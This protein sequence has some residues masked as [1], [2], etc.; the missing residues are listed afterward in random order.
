MRTSIWAMSLLFATLMG[1]F[2]LSAAPVESGAA[3]LRGVTEPVSLSGLWQLLFGLIAVLL[4][5]AVGAWLMRR[6]GSFSGTV[7]G[8]IK[9]ISALSLG[10]RERIM[11][12]QV[13][14][15]QVLIG[16]APGQIRTLH[17]LKEPV[18][19]DNAGPVVGGFAK[20][21]SQ[22]MKERRDD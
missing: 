17:V 18:A 12:I 8:G 7:P 6:I 15:E 9:I 2:N 11:L 3:S 21:L 4:M 14:E 10:T 19:A 1:G 16:V 22:M 5:I 20:R 13:G